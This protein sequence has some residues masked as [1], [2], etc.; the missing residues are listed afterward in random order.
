MMFQRIALLGK[1]GAVAENLAVLQVVAQFLLERACQV[2][3]EPEIVAQCPGCQILTDPAPMDLDLWVVVGGDGSMLNAARR[4]VQQ[5]APVVGINRGNLGFLTDISPSQL[6]A[7]LSAVLAGELQ[8]E[9]RFLLRGTVSCAATGKSEALDAL[10][11][12]VLSLGASSQ[13][14][15]FTIEIDGV[16]MCRQRADGMIITTPTGSTAY[17][18]SAGG[19]ILYPGL[20]AVALVPMLPHKLTSRPIVIDAKSHIVIRLEKSDVSGACISFDGQHSL[21]F[22]RGDVLSIKQKPERLELIH[23][24]DYDYFATL[25]DKLRWESR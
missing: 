20:S 4:A 13:L 18:L 9:Q 16:L 17:S 19:P 2:F 11:D 10:N 21:L 23:P 3:C 12:I 25:R 7:K 15:E 22:G 8:R 6:Q 14:I 1:P 5:G 24:T